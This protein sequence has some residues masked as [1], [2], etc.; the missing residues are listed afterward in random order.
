MQS[1][2][3]DNVSVFRD[4]EKLAEARAKI[5]ELRD[6]FGE[7]RIDDKGQRFNL[8][9]TE[10]FEVGCLLDVALATVASAERRTESRGAHY[11]EDYPE[12]DDESWLR[13]TLTHLRPR[14]QLEFADRPV[15]ITRFE[16]KERTY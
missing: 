2:M 12:R 10:A 15:T 4:A 16:P 1:I 13:H 5:E 6:R 9:L 3:T 11:R 14:G 8:D 7:V